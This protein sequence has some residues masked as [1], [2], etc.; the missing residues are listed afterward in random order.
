VTF[1]AIKIVL[2]V[3]SVIICLELPA[4]TSLCKQT[5][6]HQLWTALLVKQEAQGA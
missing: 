4:N 2:V 6:I 5:Q 3:T 1:V